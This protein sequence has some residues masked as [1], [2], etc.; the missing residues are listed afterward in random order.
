MPLSEHVYCVTITFKMT[1]WVEQ[2]ICI[3][4]CVKLNIPLQK[5]FRWFRRPQLWATG[6]W[7]FHHDN[8]PDHASCHMQSFRR[9]I[10]SL[11]WLSPLQSRFGVLQLLAFPKTKITLERKEIETV[12]EIQENTTG[13]LMVI[14]RT[15]W[16]PE[17]PTLK[18]TEASLSYVQCFLYLLQ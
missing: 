17:V 9:N 16:G 14:G 18:G 10:K 4:F 2:R 5:L 8:V 15:V 3:R 13:R 6:D 12:D 7:Q 1:E 11:R